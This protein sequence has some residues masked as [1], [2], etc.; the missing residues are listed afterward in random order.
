ME[1]MF[2]I[3]FFTGIAFTS[4]MAVAIFYAVTIMFGVD[5][6]KKKEEPDDLPYP[7]RK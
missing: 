5:F 7:K 4:F 1:I 6:S 2:F 3:G